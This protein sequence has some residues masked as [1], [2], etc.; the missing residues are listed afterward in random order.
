VSSESQ[1]TLAVGESGQRLILVIDHHCLQV[2]VV[3]EMLAAEGSRY[4]LAVMDQGQ[5]ALDFLLRRS[6]Y[7]Q[8]QRPDLILLDLDLPDCSGQEVLSQLKADSQ[9]RRIPL[10]VFTH[11]AAAADIQQ[12]YRQQGNC[13]VVKPGDWAAFK[14]TVRQIEAF[15]L[16]IVTL[17]PQ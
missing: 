13:Y 15:W 3:Q 17:P 14:A 1:N 7:E 16:E 6:P 4:Q 10:I 8:A 5:P 11:S 12:T 9:L 2:E